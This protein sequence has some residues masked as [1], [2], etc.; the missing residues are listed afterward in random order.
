MTDPA[1]LKRLEAIHGTRFKIVLM[2]FAIAF[3]I[4]ANEH[5]IAIYKEDGCVSHVTI[6]GTTLAFLQS[7]LSKNQSTASKK[8]D[9]HMQGQATIAQ[10]WQQFFFNLDVDWQALL[11]PLLSEQ[12]AYHGIKTFSFLK[13]KIIQV[14]NKFL[15]DG[16][17]YLKYEKKILV[18]HHLVKQFSRGVVDTSQAVDRL[19]ARIHR[20]E[21]QR[22]V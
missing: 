14:K 15:Q 1:S 19:E 4:E 2:D 10:A 6:T 21:R 8:F 13:N 3:I 5:A 7:F 12:G 22:N 17:D 9:L 18:P 16:S 20:L 11:A